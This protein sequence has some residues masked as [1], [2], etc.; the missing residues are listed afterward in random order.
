MQVQL[1]VVPFTLHV[2]TG[3]LTYRL[4]RCCVVQYDV[5]F[6]ASRCVVE[7]APL[8]MLNMFDV[9][10]GITTSEYS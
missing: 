10:E 8:L 4:L 6:I 5:P 9:S 7:C 3:N 1:L 2:A